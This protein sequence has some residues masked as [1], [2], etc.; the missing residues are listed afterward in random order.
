MDELSLFGGILGFDRGRAVCNG[1]PLDRDDAVGASGQGRAGH[2]LYAIPA[3]ERQGRIA[4]GLCGLDREIPQTVRKIGMRDRDAI[5]HDP[6]ERRLISLRH[7]ALTQRAAAGRCD[8][9]VL[10]GS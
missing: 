3:R 7:D 10:L 2:N 9:H 6:I 8:R 4:R 5:H 1:D